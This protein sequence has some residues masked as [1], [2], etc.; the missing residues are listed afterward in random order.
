MINDGDNRIDRYY[1]WPLIVAHRGASAWEKENSLQAFSEAIEIGC[2][3][4]EFDVRRTADDVCIVHHDSAIQGK[5]I[6]TL[7]YQDL[8]ALDDDIATLEEVLMLTRGRIKLDVEL[9]E[10][11]YEDTVVKLILGYFSNDGFIITS[12][13]GTSLDRIK[14]HYPY[15]TTGLLVGKD[16]EP[17]SDTYPVELAVKCNADV[18]A[19]DWRRLTPLLQEKAQEN[20]LPVFIWTVNSRELIRDFI[21][22]DTITGI[23]TDR[24]DIALSLKRFS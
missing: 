17:D 13:N 12:F 11:G 6:Q 18:I 5:E 19:I 14:K 4:I 16:L 23:I 7:S 22:N 3:M 8:R 24:P 10:E 9:K 20:H 1:R 21:N 2:D 15:I